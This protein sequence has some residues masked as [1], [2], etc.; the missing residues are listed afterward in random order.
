M[1]LPAGDHCT[2]LRVKGKGGFRGA[3]LFSPEKTE[4][5]SL[6]A[7]ASSFRLWYATSHHMFVFMGESGA[8]RELRGI[9]VGSFY[10]KDVGQWQ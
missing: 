4:D 6:G 9:N 1:A 2:E 8:T 5:F 10:G 7:I 3:G